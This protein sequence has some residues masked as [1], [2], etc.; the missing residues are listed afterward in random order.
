MVEG[1]RE[2]RERWIHV[3]AGCRGSWVC[4]GPGRTT[5]GVS[6]WVCPRFLL[7]SS[8]FRCNSAG[9]VD[10]LCPVACPHLI[11]SVVP[12]RVVTLTADGRLA[13][14]GSTPRE[15]MSRVVDMVI[16]RAS[17]LSPVHRLGGGMHLRGMRD[18]FASCEVRCRLRTARARH[19][20]S[21]RRPPSVG[22]A[23]PPPPL[24]VPETPPSHFEP[25]QKSKR[26]ATG[27]CSAVARGVATRR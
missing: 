26:G 18:A 17:G 22:V 8:P 11:G 19:P 10:G 14:P 15:C 1:G 5:V 2:L 21:S 13:G 20:S 16:G 24:H 23:S 9:V 6:E 4:R 12:S 25:R 3:P 7:V 27:A